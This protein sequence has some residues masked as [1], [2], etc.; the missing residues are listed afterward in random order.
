MKG[1]GGPSELPCL[2][3]SIHHRHES[4]ARSRLPRRILHSDLPLISLTNV[5]VKPN[6]KKCTRCRLVGDHS[7]TEAFQAI[8]EA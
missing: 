3:L 2:C 6:V 8:Y 1:R 7:W 5:D 4:D